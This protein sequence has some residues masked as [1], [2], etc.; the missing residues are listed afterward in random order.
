MITTTESIVLRGT[1]YGETSLVSTQFTR[2]YGI[3]SYM[4]QGV[5]TASGRGRSS[6]A[7][8]LQPG[9]I[10]DIT[11]YQKSGANLQRLKEFSPAVIYNSI[12]DE[13]IKNSVA[14]FSVEVLLRLLP[15]SAPLPELFDFAT[16]YLQSLDRARVGD[17]GNYPLYFVLE[18]TRFMGYELSGAYSE[19]TPFLNL[20]E[21]GFS[22]E[23]PKEGTRV[24]GQD[25]EALAALMRTGRFEDLGRIA[26]NGESRQ[27]LLEWFLA[28]LARHTDHMGQIRSLAVLQAVLR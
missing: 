8:L 27:R 14:L 16:D 22:A 4:V 6:R 23:A 11:V 1:K 3:Q 18:C 13:V 9:M 20:A 12:H 25:S 21:G 17:V 26:L 5:R 7:G 19:A 10:L 28:F 24:T 15:E 2:T